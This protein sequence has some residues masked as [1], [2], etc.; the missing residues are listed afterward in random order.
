MRLEER[1][2]R[3]RLFGACLPAQ[4]HVRDGIE[5]GLNHGLGRHPGRHVTGDRHAEPMCFFDDGFDD[6]R[7]HQGI[8]L[9]L[10]EAVCVVLPDDRCAPRLESLR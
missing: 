10:L 1:D 6:I 4:L 2:L 5:T 8:D 7:R 3:P 9:H